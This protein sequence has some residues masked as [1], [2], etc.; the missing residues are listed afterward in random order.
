MRN[1]VRGRLIY[2]LFLPEGKKTHSRYFHDLKSHTRNITLG[3]AATTE[4]RNKDFIVL[5]DKVQ[6][7]VVL[8]RD[9]LK[10]R[11][12]IDNHNLLARKR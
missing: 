5:V 10:A 9:Q 7:T 6:A 11:R 12:G 2:L 8:N 1:K 4:T 3:L